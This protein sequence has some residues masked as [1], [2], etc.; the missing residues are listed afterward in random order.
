MRVSTAGSNSSGSIS[1]FSACQRIFAVPS[2][3]LSSMRM[4]WVTDSASGASLAGSADDLGSRAAVRQAAARRTKLSHSRPAHQQGGDRGRGAVLGRRWH[5]GQRLA[6]QLRRVGAARG[7][8]LATAGRRRARRGRR[9]RRSDNAGPPRR[10]AVQ[11]RTQP[12]VFE[13][14]PV[15]YPSEDPHRQRQQRGP[16]VTHEA[17]HRRLV[18]EVGDFDGQGAAGLLHR[19]QQRHVARHGCASGSAPG[20]PG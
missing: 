1:P 7:S 10:A 19:R 4:S 13:P 18:R 9:S 3:N 8:R 11:P 5:G 17:E 14:W 12:A 2:A 15:G 16:G 20:R 6:R